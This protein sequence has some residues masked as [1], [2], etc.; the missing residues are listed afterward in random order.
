[1]IAGGFEQTVNRLL[2]CPVCKGELEFRPDAALCDR[3]GMR[4]ARA[5][6]DYFDLLPRHSPSSASSSWAE[7]QREMEDWYQDLLATPAAA[8]Q[9]ITYEYA[10]F[11]SQ[12][13]TLSGRILDVGGGLGVVRQYLPRGV[14]YIV[15]DPS[16]KWLGTEWGTMTEYF[17]RLKEAAGFIRGVGEYLPFPARTFDAV[18]A[19]WS[20]NHTSDQQQVFQEAQR[21]LQPGGRFLVV[22]EDMEPMW[23]DLVTNHFLAQGKRSVA[24]LMHE[25]LQVALGRREW[26]LQSDHARIR[27]ADVR[28]WSAQ[29]FKVLRRYWVNKYLAYDFQR[30]S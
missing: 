26:P 10:P 7:R 5:A 12:L 17:P 23:R 11:A 6:A 25:K 20:L 16:L 18:L 2:V 8:G 9:C 15:I 14:E 27:E 13:A 24:K 21:V 3:C 29:G 30:T 22:L 4:F 19:F 28:R 1:M